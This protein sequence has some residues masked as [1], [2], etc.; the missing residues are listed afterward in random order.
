MIHL[1]GRFTLIAHRGDVRAGRVLADFPNLILDNGLNRIGTLAPLN[2][3]SV[4]SGSS[5]V[6]ASQSALSNL[7]ATSTTLHNSI[8]GNETAGGYQF[9]RITYRFAA[10]TAT[11]NLTE[12][13]VGFNNGTLFSR[14]LIVDAL[15][16]PTTVTVLADEILDVVYELRQYWP[17]GDVTGSLTL[18]GTP[19]SYTLRASNVGAWANM[20]LLTGFG[21][22]DGNY[23]A[24]FRAMNGGTLGTITEPCGGSTLAIVNGTW[25][26][27]VEN[28]LQR[29][30]SATFDTTA[31][32][33]SFDKLEIVTP[34][35]GQWKIGFAAPIPKTNLNALT[36]QLALSWARR[37]L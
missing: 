19:Y 22:G 27:Y 25:L 8:S 20:N 4:G 5:A 2:R 31:P 6:V 9:A 17:T 34:Y 33:T 13:G 15:G 12:V 37:T 36:L 21:Y 23:P 7:V 28:S 10:G 30:F 14:A 32:T 26:S 24:Q 11:G 29:R 3:C 35:T 1:A 16:A 18:D